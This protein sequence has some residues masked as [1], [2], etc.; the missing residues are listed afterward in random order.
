MAA[1]LAGSVGMLV[2]VLGARP[3]PDDHARA[4][5][6][7]I[8]RDAPLVITCV[9]RE[10][11]AAL[12]R[13]AACVGRD[14][15]P[16]I[17]VFDESFVDHAVSFSAFTARKELYNCWNRPGKTTF[18][19]TTYQPNTVASLHFLQ[20][21]KQ[22][23]PEFHGS[24]LPELDRIHA[25]LRVRRDYF[26]RLYSPS[27]YRLI[28]ASGFD[29]AALRATGDFLFVG[30]RRIFD[31]VSGVACSVRGHNPSTYVGEIDGLSSLPDC[32]AELASRLRDLTELDCVLPA[33]SGA[34]AVESALKLALVAQFPR[35]HVLALQAGFGG[36][37]LLALTGTANPAYKAHIDPLYA[38]VLYVD[39]F[40]P[41]AESQID[42]VLTQHAVAVVQV[43]L[44][45]AVGGV[46]R[47]PEHVIRH[48]QARRQQAGYLLLVDEVQT[49]MYRT[50]PF[51]LAGAMGLAP[52]LL[53]LGKATSDMMF[54]CALVLYSAALKARLD[55]AGS[56]LPASI[57]RT[58]GYP[59][60]YRTVLNVL[61]RAEELSLAQRVT[62]SG[63]LFARL[64]R[65]GLA[66]CKAVRDVRV[67]GLLI[68]IELDRESGA[69]QWLRQRLAWPYLYS[70]LRHRDYP[71]LAGFC[72]YEPNVLKITPSLTVAPDEI[73]AVCGSIIDVLKRPFP[74][75]LAAALAGLLPVPGLWRKRHEHNRVRALEPAA[76]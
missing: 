71:V 27:L 12:R 47:V 39:P 55:R 34:N 63:A 22:A 10:G 24:L 26:R 7:L 51:T 3:L 23:D 42:A 57:G 9:D 60:A 72:Q 15:V 52:D 36:K 20:C 64:L 74:R 35:R 44:V 16:D 13:G 25:D 40:A 6:L 18:H 28:R 65:E 48:L 56:D 4:I 69:R 54:P 67:Y 1:A 73:R 45:Q 37:T 50:G 38:D 46:R 5:R 33:V 62:G 31:G 29:T 75:L 32:Q 21:L 19:S 76:R 49:G 43:E 8:R 66:P 61:R 70:M 59:F 11:L 30:G 53:L 17:V 41:D 68:G 58:Y 2:L 14:F